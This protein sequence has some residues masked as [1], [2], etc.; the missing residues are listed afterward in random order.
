MIW[1][2]AWFVAKRRTGAST[3]EAARLGRGDVE[4]RKSLW[5]TTRRQNRW[6]THGGSQSF[7]GRGA[8]EVN[9]DQAIVFSS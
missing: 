8:E 5:W 3:V 2:A 1:A 4:G 7:E 9:A 6:N